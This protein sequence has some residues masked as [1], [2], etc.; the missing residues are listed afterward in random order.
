[1]MLQTIGL[2]MALVLLLTACANVDDRNM[3]SNRVTEPYAIDYHENKL[4]TPYNQYANREQLRDINTLRAPNE[5]FMTN[6]T[7]NQRLSNV[8]SNIDAVNTA[9]V[10]VANK[11]AYVAILL[12]GTATG[13]RSGDITHMRGTLPPAGKTDRVI[14]DYTEKDLVMPSGVVASPMNTKRA[15]GDVALELKTKIAKEIGKEDRSIQE[16]YVSANRNFINEM[17]RLAMMAWKGQSLKGQVNAFEKLVQKTLSANP[18]EVTFSNSS[19]LIR[20]GTDGQSG[21]VN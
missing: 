13:G 2:F 10:M 17:N 8:V 14:Q 16:V 1:M 9:W 18:K 19:E 21:G 11:R 3:E 15:L 12:D 6:L 20:Q 7:F 5:H 4:A